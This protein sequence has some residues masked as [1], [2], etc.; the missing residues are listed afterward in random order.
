LQDAAP[1][2]PWPAIETVLTEE[3]GPDRAVEVDPVPLAAA[4]IGQ[5]HAG[6][7]P[8]GTEVVV[9]V[10]RP[11]VVELV[12]IDLALLERVARRLAHG[13][14]ARSG[15]DIVG[16]VHQF[17]TT[18]R[19]ELD[20]VAEAGN[21]RRFAV[22]FARD[23]AVHIPWIVDELSTARVLTLQRIRG[24]K[25]NDLPG[26]AA[27]GIDRAA[28]ASRAA[29]VTLQ[30]VFRDGFFHA[31]PHPG[32]FFIE[33]DG[34]LGIIDFGMVG[35]VDDVTRV[36]LLALLAAVATGNSDAV[37][38][39]F[40]ALGVANASVARAALRDDMVGLLHS[41]LDRPVGDVE[42]GELFNGLFAVVRRHH[43]LLPASLTLLLKTVVMFEGLGASLDPS[44]RLIDA[45]TSFFGPT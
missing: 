12:D 40:L 42:I 6:V 18:L 4:S 8:D 29:R 19:A 3:L 33:C 30:M 14:F 28:L 9:K 43:L 39:G 41:Q 23:T 36:Q 31:D 5:A 25:V 16:L 37:V 27:A 11:G 32:N 35:T 17:A 15:Y 1:A 20:Y 21:A 44:F 2:E 7:L 10:R 22:N 24:V 34:R 45:V 26:M 13:W 38:E